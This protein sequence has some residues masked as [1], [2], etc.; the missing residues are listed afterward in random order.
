LER[1]E[2]LEQLD[3]IMVE[4]EVQLHWEF[5]YLQ[6][7]GL[8]VQDLLLQLLLQI[9]EELEELEQEDTSKLVELQEIQEQLH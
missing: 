5:F 2:L 6:L 8:V 1:P 7:V 3:L 4:L 9:Q